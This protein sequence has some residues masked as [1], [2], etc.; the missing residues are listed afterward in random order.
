MA[1]VRRDREPLFP[2]MRS[3]PFSR[4]HSNGPS[5]FPPLLQRPRPGGP[6]SDDRPPRA[7]P[8]RPM[9]GPKEAPRAPYY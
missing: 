9:L 5:V 3:E 8:H 7:I 6:F 1:L 2:S 4:A